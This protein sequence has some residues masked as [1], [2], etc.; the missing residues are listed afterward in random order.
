MLFRSLGGLANASVLTT[1]D[2]KDRGLRMHYYE[3]ADRSNFL[4][5]QNSSGNLIYLQAAVE[6]SSNV[7]TGTYG[8]VQFGQLKLSNVNASTSQTSGA[9]QVVVG[10]GVQGRITANNVVVDKNLTA[11]GEEAIITFAPTN[12]GYV[13]I[14][15]ATKGS[16]DN[17]AIGQA[18]PV[19][20]TVT[21][22]TAITQ[23][24]FNGS[25]NIT[26]QPAGNIN[27]NPST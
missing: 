14:N 27:I 23:V 24:R 5:W 12:T 17:M 16:M 8:S 22:L 25:G 19:E 11:S 4:G 3:G 20:A 15:P 13:T 6:S 10:V 7:F 26:M 9:L 21:T 1:N 18:T 2:G